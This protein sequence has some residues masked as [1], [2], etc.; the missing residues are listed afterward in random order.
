MAN[1]FLNEEYRRR[2]KTGLT[3]RLFRHITT[4]KDNITFD[5]GRFV[6]VVLAGLVIFT[7]L[8]LA[9]IA[10]AIVWWNEKKFD[11]QGFGVGVASIFGGF[12]T[13]LGAFAAYVAMD[14][15]SKAGQ[16]VQQF[17]APPVTYPATVSPY[18]GGPAYQG[19]YQSPYG[20]QPPTVVNTQVQLNG[21]EEGGEQGAVPVAPPVAQPKQVVV[22]PKKP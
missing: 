8:L 19:V 6:V 7:V 5:T 21:Q 3:K 10:V 1:E 4:D 13:L 16:E 9:A 15:R 17:P 12:A 2:S 22:I 18:P 11:F 20:G 14:A